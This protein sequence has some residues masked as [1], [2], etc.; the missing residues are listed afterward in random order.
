MKSPL[1]NIASEIVCLAKSRHKN[2]AFIGDFGVVTYGEIHEKVEKLASRLAGLT[3]HVSK[4]MPRIGVFCPENVEHAV[5]MLAVMRCGACAV[6]I[7]GE[8]SAAEREAMRKTTSLDGILL[9]GGSAWPELP[10]RGETLVDG[11]SWL[12]LEHAAPEFSEEK[13][14]ELNPAFVRFS[15][16]TTGRSKGVVLSH[17]SLRS[18][19]DSTNR[20]L[21]IGK[22]DKVL[23]TLPMAHHFAAS[24]MLYLRVGAAVI[25]PRSSLADDMLGAAVENRATVF[26]GSPFQAAL[27]A[28]ENSGRAWPALR[29]AVSTAA[30]LT[31]DTAAK[32]LVRYGVPLTQGFGIIEAG[33]PILNTEHAADDPLAVG[34]EDD[35]EV[36]LKGDDGELCLRG[37][38][39]FDA[40]LS[41]WQTRAEV[42]ADGWFHTGDLATRGKN[43]TIRL[44][45]RLKSVINVGGSKC[46]PEEIEALLLSHPGVAD[47]RVYG[48]EHVRWGMLPAAQIVPSNLDDP[49]REKDLSAHCRAA[50]AAY[51]IPVRFEIVAELPRTASGKIRRF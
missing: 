14:S 51:K 41:P 20:R 45:G 6:P 30:A 48:I 8:L 37:P 44:C 28:A 23:W 2:P 26:Y 4:R 46:F 5:L 49:P 1:Y 24:I 17:E 36:E 21:R 9:A 11:V 33:V 10:G 47:A 27:L 40:Y 18:R 38:G 43:E 19:L 34:K 25:L 29:L 22:E 12:P 50:L 32:F 3:A 31:A 15:S 7:A 35:F 39:M 13:F 42:M 16:G